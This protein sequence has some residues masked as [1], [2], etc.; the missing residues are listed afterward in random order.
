MTRIRKAP[1]TETSPDPR[2]SRPQR[3]KQKQDTW[4]YLLAARLIKLVRM[5]APRHREGHEESPAYGGPEAPH[6][7]QC[8]VSAVTKEKSKV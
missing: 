4:P 3:E 6:R 8:D 1:A 7:C 2:K 5:H